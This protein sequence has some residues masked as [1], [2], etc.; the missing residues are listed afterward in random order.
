M[1]SIW[2]ICILGVILGACAPWSMGETTDDA[3]DAGAARQGEPV[4]VVLS[5]VQELDV[6]IVSFRSTDN[7]RQSWI[8]GFQNLDKP[9]AFTLEFL[10]HDSF[11]TTFIKNRPDVVSEYQAERRAALQQNKQWDRAKAVN[12]RPRFHIKVDASRSMARILE[13][14]EIK[15]ATPEP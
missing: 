9:E 12:P 10:E 2:S 6:E 11:A 7:R 14:K 4:N 1:K 15:A 13:W 5:G 8:L 3:V